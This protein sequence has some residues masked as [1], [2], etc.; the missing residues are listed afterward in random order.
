MAGTGAILSLSANGKQDKYLTS[1][2]GVSF[3]DFKSVNHTPF[4]LFYTSRPRYRNVLPDTMWP[5][6]RT[7][8]FN[9]NPKVSGDV[10]ANA[11]LKLT[12]PGL[13]PGNAYC[14]QIGNALIKEYSIRINETV[15]QTIPGDWN[16]I[17]DELYAELTERYAKRFLVNG[18]N[19]PGTLPPSNVDLPVYVPLN[20]F[21]SR[22]TE[23]LPGNSN[24]VNSE[25]G[26]RETNSADTHRAFFLLCACTKQQVYVDI[27]FNPVSFFSNVNSI[28]VNKIQLITEEAI[29]SPEEVI[30]Y[31]NRPH[32]IFYNSVYK[33]PTL[34]VD[35]GEGVVNSTTLQPT[36]CY[37]KYKDDILAPIPVKAFH[38]F[39]RDQRYENIN[40]ST[41]FL[42]RYNFSNNPIS[43]VDN[44]YLYQILSNARIYINNILQTGII[45]NDNPPFNGTAGADYFRYVIP[46][47][48]GFAIP[49]RNI[50]TYS[51]SL[52][53]REPTPIGALDFDIME[54]SKTYVNG[55]IQKIATSNAYNLNTI[56]IGY[57]ILKYENDFCSLLYA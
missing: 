35:K 27:T 19:S 56:Y 55:H 3:W 11:F 25:S 54:S 18:G 22:T 36:G 10:L 8:T 34:R 51:F 5:F 12:L 44:E 42:N 17:H 21:F 23:I 53:P 4:T 2:V 38:W 57:I 31:K 41:H 6:G 26:A 45:G 7:I 46:S 15:I 29:L 52:N 37:D 50:Y 33:Q 1:N 20:F 43:T 24:N 49:N 28:S 13:P 9:I 30:F 32:S 14:E 47:T 40:V 16:V 48:H 39:L